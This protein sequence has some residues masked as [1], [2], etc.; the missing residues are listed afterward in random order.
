MEHETREKL[1]V[2]EPKVEQPEFK[3]AGIENDIMESLM[4]IS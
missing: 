1:S 3:T 2:K 4:K